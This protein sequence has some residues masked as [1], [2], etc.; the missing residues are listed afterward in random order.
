MKF[1]TLSTFDSFPCLNDNTAEER[2]KTG[3]YVDKPN[4]INT[5]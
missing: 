3:E 1:T 5:K 2:I 4:K